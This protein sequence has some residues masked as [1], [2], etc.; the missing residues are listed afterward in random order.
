MKTKRASKQRRPG[1]FSGAHGSAKPNGQQSGVFTISIDD[2][3]VEY[4][5]QMNI[6]SHHSIAKV[7]RKIRQAL[8]CKKDAGKIRTH[9]YAA[10]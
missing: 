2:G 8:R 1:Q 4:A 3:Y 7:E 9:G 10:L 6:G 5:Y